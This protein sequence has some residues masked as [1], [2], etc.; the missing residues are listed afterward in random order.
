MLILQFATSGIMSISLEG[1]AISKHLKEP[2]LNIKSYVSNSKEINLAA[3][4]MKT[5]TDF[6][7]VE[8]IPIKSAKQISI[9]ISVNS[10]QWAWFGSAQT[11]LDRD[12][13]LIINDTFQSGIKG[14]VGNPIRFNSYPVEI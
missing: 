6:G 13:H 3:N 12:G 8:L 1:L 10:D 7:A 2:V 9:N 4:D 14:P 5:F 11:I